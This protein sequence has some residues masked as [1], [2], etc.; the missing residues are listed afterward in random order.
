MI[1]LRRRSKASVWPA[2]LFGGVHQRYRF[3]M[4]VIAA[5]HRTGRY[6]ES[7]VKPGGL[8]QAHDGNGT[9]DTVQATGE[10]PVGTV[11]LSSA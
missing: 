1:A 9:L 3:S 11:M 2:A 8:D 4:P 5:I 10:K 6:M 7:W